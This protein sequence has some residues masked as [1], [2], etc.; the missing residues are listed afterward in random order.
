MNSFLRTLLVFV[1]LA[2][3]GF[4]A[5]NFA[6]TKKKAASGDAKAQSI[7]GSMYFLGEEVPKDYAEAVKWW[8]LAA[9][10]EDV[11]AQYYLGVMYDTGTGVPKEYAEAISWYRKAADQGYPSAQYNLGVMYY[12]GRGLPK[13]LVQ[14][15]AWWNIAGARGDETAKKDLA[16]VEKDMTPEQQAEAMKQARELFAKLPK[17]LVKNIGVKPPHAEGGLVAAHQTSHAQ[18]KEIPRQA[19]TSLS[20]TTVLTTRQAGV[21]NI[22][23]VGR[24][25]RW[26][27]YGEYL[28]EMLQTIQVTW[29]R[30][31]E[32]SRVSPPRGSHVVVTFNIN[33]K[34]ETNIVKVEDADSGKQGVFSCQ[35]AITYPQPYPKWSQQ[36]IAALGDQQELSLA[37][38]YQ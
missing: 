21:A 14:A 23:I 26:S 28:N 20:P 25:K 13:D 11:S 15:H 31:L 5:D 38:Y 10:Q 30:I 7:L 33:A 17:V 24:D 19:S 9:E 16:N 35:N 27:E 6:E 8:R 2:A 18:S 1:L 36:M 12:K 4:A 29:Y 22:G 37:F 32:E 3:A 34:G